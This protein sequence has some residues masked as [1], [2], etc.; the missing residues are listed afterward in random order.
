MI[1]LALLAS[2]ADCEAL[3]A[4]APDQ[5]TLRA[6]FVAAGGWTPPGTPSGV[7]PLPAF[8]RVT[9]VARPVAGSEIGFEVWLPAEGWSGRLRMSGNGGYSSALPYG[10][11]AEALRAG[12]VAVG[13]DTGHQ[14]DDPV[15]GR[16]RPEAIVDWAHRAVHVSVVQA[17]AVTQLFY[18]QAPRWSYFSGCSTGG[19]QALME[20]QRY[21]DDFDGVVAGAPGNYRTR[22]NAAFLWQFVSNRD[23]EGRQI[24]PASKLAILQAA[25]VAAC[26]RRPE[27]G[28]EIWVTEPATCAFDPLEIA[29]EAEDRSDCLTPPQVEAV[30]RM[31]AGA[32]NP[33]T[34][35]RIA[36]GWPPGTE[37]GWGFYW[38]DPADPSQ[39]ARANFWRYW[40][41]GDP[42][43]SWRSFDFDADWRRAEAGVAQVVDASDP[44]IGAFAR[45][46]GKLIQWHGGA[47]PVVPLMDSIAYHRAVVEQL[48]PAEADKS[49]RLFLA[50]G[51][52]HCG[53]GPGHAPTG[54]QD[55]IEAWVETG[56]APRALEARSPT[57]ETR[58]LPP[59]G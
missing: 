16:D 51:V 6:E 41:F 4:R 15:F 43:W 42:D 29:C 13:T 34:G 57:G 56:V 3:N 24:V 30:R 49:Y 14:G 19:H 33:R 55:A 23:A 2:A 5:T 9:G 21:P 1:A 46:G 35:E 22:L 11:M 8:C 59:A 20:V 7:P 54:L 53:G 39:P 38:A 47:D 32:H 50:P 44:D 36:W 10:G 25:S 26:K 18:G 31:Y 27:E 12:A 37:A 52:G 28:P 40:V 45:R 58:L 48:G 17:K